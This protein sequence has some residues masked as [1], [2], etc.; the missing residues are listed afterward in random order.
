VEKS[1]K[2]I[3]T[4][5]LLHIQKMSEAK[6]Y[7]VYIMSNYTNS[8]LY[9]GVTNNLLKRVLEHKEK[10]NSTSFTSK[11]NV[12]KLVYYEIGGDVYEQ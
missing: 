7:Y 9:I 1:A 10:S 5:N 12:D 8:V 3:S 4:F 11:Y 6:Q 2:P